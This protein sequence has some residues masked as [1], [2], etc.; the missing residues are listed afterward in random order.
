V[1][2]IWKLVKSQKIAET[3]YF[4]G[5]KN[6]FSKLFTRSTDFQNSFGLGIGLASLLRNKDKTYQNDILK[7]LVQ[8]F[9]NF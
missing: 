6:R 1:K 4:R 9:S 3:T 5:H 2:I 8:D 7:M